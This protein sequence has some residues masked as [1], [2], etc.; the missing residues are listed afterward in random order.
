MCEYN[1]I[2]MVYKTIFN[3]DLKK[4]LSKNEILFVPVM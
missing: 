1:W 3:N 2:F 4:S